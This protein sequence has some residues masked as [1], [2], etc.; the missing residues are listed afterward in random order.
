MTR[1]TIGRGARGE[2]VADWQAFLRGA[3]LYLGAIDGDFGPATEAATIAWQDRAGG[4]VRPDGIVGPR[5]WAAAVAAGLPLDEAEPD[6]LPPAPGGLRQYSTVEMHERFGALMATPDP[7]PENPERVRIVN[8]DGR[9][10]L[11][12]VVI[13]ELEDR[14]GGPRGGKV[15][16]HADVCDDFRALWDA[17]A[18]ADLTRLV[19]S[20]GGSFAERTI[21]GSRTSLS[22]HSWGTAFD[23]NAA[24]NGLGRAPAPTGAPGCLL[25]LVPIAERMGWV[26]GGR[27]KRPDGM[28]F[29]RGEG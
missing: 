11:A 17:W 28:H 6:D 18:A 25:P 1:A 14:Q 9:R 29:E 5:T 15:I 23:L 3:G 16:L 20:W 27:W 12:A 4:H 26:W 2:L 22:R 19:R 7:S 13:P 24:W 8:P 10:K 21:R